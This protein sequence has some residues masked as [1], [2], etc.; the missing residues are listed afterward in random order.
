MGGLLFWLDVARDFAIVGR[1]PRLGSPPIAW[2]VRDAADRGVNKLAAVGSPCVLPFVG[3][4]LYALVR[5]RTRLDDVHE[6][7]LWMQLA[8]ATA[9]VAALPVLLRRRSSGTSSPARA[10]PRC[11]AA[12]APPAARPDEFAWAACPYCGDAPRT[13][14]SGRPRSRTRAAEVTALKP[15]RRGGARLRQRRRPPRE[16]PTARSRANPRSKRPV[17]LDSRRDQHGARGRARRSNGTRRSTG[18]RSPSSSRRSRT[19]G[20]ARRSRSGCAS[21]SA[22]S[23]SPCR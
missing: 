5:P 16:G 1:R 22:R 6:R 21:R 15:A 14:R 17:S 18:R 13:R 3:A 8:E 19:R 11:C 4:F 10:A 12:A 7:R 20:S 9:R 2:V 23:S